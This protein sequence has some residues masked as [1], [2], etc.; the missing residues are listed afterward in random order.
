MRGRQGRG[1]GSYIHSGYLVYLA[2][3]ELNR[4][5]EA[6]HAA[7]SS[8]T[9]DLRYVNRKGQTPPP[10]GYKSRVSVLVSNTGQN[11]STMLDSNLEQM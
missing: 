1:P 3:V 5:I 2:G 9:S 8:E 11:T 4:S 6:E 7:R 10:V